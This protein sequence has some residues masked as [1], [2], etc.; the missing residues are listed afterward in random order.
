M[1]PHPWE[2][3]DGGRRGAEIGSAFASALILIFSDPE[4]EEINPQ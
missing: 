4:R 2:G 1:P 3:W